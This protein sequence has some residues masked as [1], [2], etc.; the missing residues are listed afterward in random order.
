LSLS[1][2]AQAASRSMSLPASPSARLGCDAAGVWHKVLHEDIRGQGWAANLR[3]RLAETRPP[4][5]QDHSKRLGEGPERG[6]DPGYGIVCQCCSI[7]KHCAADV[8]IGALRCKTAMVVGKLQK[9]TLWGLQMVIAQFSG[10]FTSSKKLAL[11]HAHRNF[12]DSPLHHP[13]LLMLQGAMEN[14]VLLLWG[15]GQYEYV[16]DA[17]LWMQPFQRLC[18]G[19][20]WA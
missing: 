19:L 8:F 14:E 16:T 9:C 3:I 20:Q 2:P 1:I 7:Q 6:R 17:H 5:T 10:G 11:Q 15:Q 13:Q 18:Q 12:E 4:G